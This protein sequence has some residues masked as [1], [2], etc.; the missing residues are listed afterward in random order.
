MVTLDVV[1]WLRGAQPAQ[2]L[3]QARSGGPYILDAHPSLAGRRRK[4]VLL[5]KVWSCVCNRC[6]RIVTPVGWRSAA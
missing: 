3:H 4:V 1:V 5:A 6:A 2:V